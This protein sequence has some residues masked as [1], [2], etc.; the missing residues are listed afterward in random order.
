MRP[1]AT[2]A[3]KTG[4]THRRRERIERMEGT[5]AGPGPAHIRLPI[6]SE[7]CPIDA[8]TRSVASAA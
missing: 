7:E 8:R 2:T 3:T 5:S 4:L 6:P 1:A